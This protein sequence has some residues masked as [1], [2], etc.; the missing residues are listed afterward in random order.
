M[1]FV[2]SLFGTEEGNG[3][4]PFA[5]DMCLPLEL[6]DCIVIFF[7]TLKCDLKDQDPDIAGS[8]SADG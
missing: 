6:R 5:I 1:I 3:L 4:S 2:L 8:E 7:K